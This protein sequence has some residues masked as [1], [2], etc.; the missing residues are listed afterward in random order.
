MS[1][2]VTILGQLAHNPDVLRDLGEHGIRTARHGDPVATR[3]VMISAHGASDKRR[4]AIESAGHHVLEA[5]CP[6]VQQAH[7][8]L[9]ML[10]LAGFYPVVIGK[11]GHVEVSGLTED[12]A[13]FRVV[14]NYEEISTIPR[15]P[16]IGVVAQTTQPIDR[17]NELVQAIRERFP[18]SDVQ[19]MDTVCR[20]TK[21]RQSAAVDLAH[22]ASV[23]IVIGGVNS[24]NTHELVN[25]CSRFCDRVHHVQ[26]AV[27][28]RGEWFRADDVVGV[29]AGTST[30]DSA[31]DEV[32]RALRAIEFPAKPALACA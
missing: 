18:G 25:T 17:V 6:L 4:R 19:F 30:P 32:E 8:E 29:T 10:L 9:R 15:H 21:D 12:L 20:P 11:R 26:R 31:I 14:E 7:R 1:S 28:L 16:K 13:D 27:D 22:R 5:T 23:V 24:N 2:P 3:T